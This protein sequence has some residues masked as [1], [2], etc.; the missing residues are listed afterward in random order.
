MFVLEVGLAVVE[1][2][3]FPLFAC[4]WV[5]PQLRVEA[6][7]EANAAVIKIGAAKFCF[8]MVN[9]NTTGLSPLM[10]PVSG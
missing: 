7:S 5:L 4:G 8:F 6:T 10:M 9:W 1:S 2:V 3:P